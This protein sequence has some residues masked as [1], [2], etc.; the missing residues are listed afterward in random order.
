MPTCAAIVVYVR[1]RARISFDT[2]SGVRL[3]STRVFSPHNFAPPGSQPGYS[4][5]R[6]FSARPHRLG[7]MFAHMLIRN[8]LAPTRHPLNRHTRGTGRAP[9]PALG[10]KCLCAQTHNSVCRWR[11]AP[12]SRPWR[13]AFY[14][15]CCRDSP[16]FRPEVSLTSGDERVPPLPIDSS[17]DRDGTRATAVVRLRHRHGVVSSIP[18]RIVRLW[19]RQNHPPELCLSGR[20][21][22]T[23]R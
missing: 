7:I 12:A 9:Y 3:L 14:S 6:Y 10:R 8:V 21:L 5:L 13:P 15:T 16:P 11:M 20:D 2:G 17:A 22:R 18:R 1:I 19:A 23:G 4:H